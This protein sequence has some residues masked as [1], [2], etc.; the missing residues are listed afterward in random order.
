MA[1]RHSPSL[2]AFFASVKLALLLLFFLAVTSIIGT[3]VPQNSSSAFYIDKFGAKTAHLIEVLQIS[4]MYNAWWFLGLLTLFA[5]NLVVCSLERIPKV[6]RLLQRDNLAITPEKLMRMRPAKTVQMSGDL[7]TTGQHVQDL[8][9][10][11]GWKP[12]MRSDDSSV[13]FFAEKGGWTRFGVYIVHLSILVI[14][15]GA[16]AGSPSL[17]RLLHMPGFAFKGSIMLPETR[18]TDFIFAADSGKK[19]DLGFTVKCEAFTIDYY[20]NGMP[21]SY[22]S[23]VTVFHG[24]TAQLHADITVNNPLTYKGVT[25]YQASYEPHSEFILTIEN[26]TSKTTARAEMPVARKLTWKEEDLQFGI[27]N[28]ESASKVASKVKLWFNDGKG[29]PSTLWV[30]VG[31]E[32]LVQGSGVTYRIRIKQMYSTG[33]QAAKDP[34]VPLVYFGCALMLFGLYVA[35]FLSHQKIFAKVTASTDDSQVFVAGTSNKNK[36]G[37]AKTFKK[38]TDSLES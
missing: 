30:K 38:F 34:G 6:V 15:L 22:L 5:I 8:L 2:R 20:A 16:L 19:I 35:F 37:F 32:T 9:K 33:L 31:E 17:A 24:E 36:T 21:K 1:T 12:L 14:F 13:L 18:Q 4:D 10:K 29:A 25:F 23:K 3:I 11:N 7:K 26:T 28:V 27:I